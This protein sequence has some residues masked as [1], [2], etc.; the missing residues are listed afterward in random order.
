MIKKL[1]S[2]FI[3]LSAAIYI[4]AK[5][6]PEPFETA[7]PEPMTPAIRQTMIDFTAQLMACANQS[8]AKQ[9]G[10]HC[11]QEKSKFKQ[12]RHAYSVMKNMRLNVNNIDNVFTIN[13]SIYYVTMSDHLENSY[14]LQLCYNSQTSSCQVYGF[15][16]I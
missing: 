13:G 3:L 14:E 11:I 9:F 4:T 5:N 12:Y 2:V 6:L 1:F 15:E 8:K 7:Q 16:E 10:K